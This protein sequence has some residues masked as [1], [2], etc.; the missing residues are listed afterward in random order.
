VVTFPE[1]LVLVT[2][3]PVATL[4]ATST[5]AMLPTPR[6]V[7]VCLTSTP[8]GEL[9]TQP[10]PPLPSATAIPPCP[11]NPGDTCLHPG[12]VVRWQTPTPTS[13]MGVQ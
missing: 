12:G 6:P 7:A 4:E 11:V 1:V 9:C 13:E 5:Y 3:T 2:H 10:E 8:R